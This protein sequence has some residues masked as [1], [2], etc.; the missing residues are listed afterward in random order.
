DLHLVMG[1]ATPVRFRVRMDGEPPGDAHGTD[2]DA[3]GDGVVGEARLY[4]LVRQR[5]PVA[6]RRF[7]IEFLDAGAE[8]FAFT[9]G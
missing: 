6:D 1:A 4:Q 2:V 8:A 5:A 7:E 9:F 3:R